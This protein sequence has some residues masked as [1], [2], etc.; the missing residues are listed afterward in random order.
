[1][2]YV[3]YN[4]ICSFLHLNYC[5]TIIKTSFFYQYFIAVLLSFRILDIQKNEIITTQL[6]ETQ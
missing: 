4:F 3:E 2:L 6:K 5:N 1:M